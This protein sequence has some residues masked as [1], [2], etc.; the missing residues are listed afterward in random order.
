MYQELQGGDGKMEDYNAKEAEMQDTSSYFSFK[1][2]RNIRRLY[3]PGRESRQDHGRR[4]IKRR[5]KRR[6]TH[7]QCTQTDELVLRACHTT[8]DK[9]DEYSI[10]IVSPITKEQIK[11]GQDGDPVLA[12]VKSWTRRLTWDD[13]SAEEADVK[14]YAAC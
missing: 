13:I 1:Y 8:E 5:Q 9:N 7:V 12:K 4:N 6:A 14:Y 11:E 10:N 2:I 3:F